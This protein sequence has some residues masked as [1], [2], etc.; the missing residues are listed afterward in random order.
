MFPLKRKIV[1]G[2]RQGQKTFYSSWHIGTDWAA[3]YEPL[4]APFDGEIVKTIP[5]KD[6]PDGGH[7]LWFRP[8]RDKTLHRY[9]H[10]DSFKMKSGRAKIG[11]LLAI[12]GN[13][14]TS[15]TPHTHN[16]ISKSGKLELGNKA[17][18]I[19]PEKYNWDSPPLQK[20]FM[21][22]TIIANNNSWTTLAEQLATLRDWFVI[23]SRGRLELVFDI[24]K[25]GFQDVPLSPF[26]TAKSVD[27]DWYRKNITPLA[28]GQGTLLL[29]NPDQ[30]P[31]GNTFGFMTYG[32][33]GRPVRMEAAA[34]EQ[35][36]G[37]NWFV[38]RG[39]HEICH[40][41]FFLT[42]QPDIDPDNPQNSIVHK[43]LYQ[44]PPKGKALLD[45]IDYAKLQAKLI[46]I[47]PTKMSQAKIVKSK[48]SNT[49][50]ICYPIPSEQHLQERVSLEGINL[51]NPIPNSDSL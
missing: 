10:L 18:F 44:D 2:Y 16:D 33:P 3:D 28:T 32:D 49:V 40:M 9:L 23:D 51:P 27:I 8:D 42:G 5:A 34:A 4:Y 39:F 31:N 20:T 29:L 46:T 12:T 30:Y 15:T 26:L 7:T 24:I 17:N 45:L 1:R 36:G 35:E 48:N 43:Y 19:D 6:A 13:T 50:Y 47:K 25:T 38:H 22:I 41:L 21:K 37:N 14:G 11:D